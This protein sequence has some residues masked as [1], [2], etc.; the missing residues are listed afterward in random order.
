MKRVTYGGA[1]EPDI[2]EW[3]SMNMFVVQQGLAIPDRTFQKYIAPA[4]DLLHDLK[5]MQHESSSNI[6]SRSYVV[7]WLQDQDGQSGTSSMEVFNL[8]FFPLEALKN[9]FLFI[10]YLLFSKSIK[11]YL[12][13]LLDF[14]SSLPRRKHPQNVLFFQAYYYN[15]K[16]VCAF[17]SQEKV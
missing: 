17:L 4:E 14:L 8:T 7:S 12:N 11:T 13:R 2:E 3:V 10:E 6:N 9:D 1:L 15:L 5:Q 16:L